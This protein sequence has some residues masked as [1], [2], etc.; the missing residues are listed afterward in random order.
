M[1]L[2]TVERWLGTDS[3]QQ[4]LEKHQAEDVT[5]QDHAHRPV[6][7]QLHRIR[8]GNSGHSVVVRLRGA[9]TPHG[10]TPLRFILARVNR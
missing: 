7:T 1:V 10:L 8:G 5:S 2:A 9:H 6:L 4:Q 3:Q